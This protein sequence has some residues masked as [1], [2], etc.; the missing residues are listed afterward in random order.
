MVYIQRK[1]IVWFIDRENKVYGLQRKIYCKVYIQRTFIVWF[2][3]GEK[4]FVWFIDR[5][6]YIVRFT[7]REH[8]LNG[9]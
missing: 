4:Y 6:K 2:I 1:Y 7:Y 3:V 8:I 9:L 5:E